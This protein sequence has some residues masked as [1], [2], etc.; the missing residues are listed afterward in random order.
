VETMQRVGAHRKYLLSLDFFE[1]AFRTLGEN[2]TLAYVTYQGKRVS[3]LL[4]LRYGDLAYHWLSGS[5]Q[6]YFHMYTQDLLHYA[7]LVQLREKGSKYCILGGGFS[8]KGSSLF[9]FKVGF[10]KSTKDFY[11][12]KRIHLKEEYDRLVK[13]QRDRGA[14]SVDFFPQYRLP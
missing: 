11:V 10:S 5:K 12:Y 1:R 8:G 6:E 4:A 3:G 13:L 14:N 7:N 9:K 2:L